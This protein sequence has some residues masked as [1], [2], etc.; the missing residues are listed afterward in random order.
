[1]LQPHSIRSIDVASDGTV[2]VGTS[3]S[4]MFVVPSTTNPPPRTPSRTPR[5]PSSSTQ[6][7]A[8]RDR[9]PSGRTPMGGGSSTVASYSASTA[10][11]LCMCGHFGEVHGLGVVQS[12]IQRIFVTG[13]HDQMLM[14]WDA[15]THAHV[16]SLHLSS[17]PLCIAIC[18]MNSLVAAG[19]EGKQRALDAAPRFVDPYRLRPRRWHDSHHQGFR[20]LP[21]A[22]AQHWCWRYC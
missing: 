8:R 15:D 6:S 14:M 13:G 10:P 22:C 20:F 11:K 1:V 21:S 7:P 2:L 12:S 9:T 3:R 19:C 16:R 17:A 4:C 18:D 5:T